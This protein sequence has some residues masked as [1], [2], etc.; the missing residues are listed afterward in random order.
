MEGA[1]KKRKLLRKT[2]N[3][4]FPTLITGIRTNGDRIYVSDLMESVLFVKYRRAENSLAIFAR[5]SRWPVPLLI[6]DQRSACS[7]MAS[8]SMLSI[9]SLSI[10]R[11][12]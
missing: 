6:A 9:I 7:H 4:G 5:P 2:E 11:A 10:C 3:R 12:V 1:T 8:P